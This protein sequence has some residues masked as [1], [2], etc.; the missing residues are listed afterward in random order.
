M[1]FPAEGPLGRG[2]GGRFSERFDE[3]VPMPRRENSFRVSLDPNAVAA[4][5][6]NG[7]AE[8]QSFLPPV[9]GRHNDDARTR[10]IVVKIDRYSGC[11]RECDCG[12][13]DESAVTRQ[14]P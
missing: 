1:D 10:P 3:S 14:R 6:L 8:P 11:K 12:E 13:K 9:D 7:A 2:E 4:R 5:N